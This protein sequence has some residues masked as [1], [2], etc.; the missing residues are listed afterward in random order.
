MRGMNRSYTRTRV[1][2][3]LLSENDTVF[4][5]YFRK[6]IVSASNLLLQREKGIYEADVV[7]QVKR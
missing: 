6:N 1:Y 3:L 4:L 2:V 7:T 5:M